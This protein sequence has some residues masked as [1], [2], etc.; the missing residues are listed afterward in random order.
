MTLGFVFWFFMLLWLIHLVA[1][2]RGWIADAYGPLGSGILVFVLFFLVGWKVY[3][4]P[5][6]G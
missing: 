3:G 4:F 5:I 1:W 6:T 2:N